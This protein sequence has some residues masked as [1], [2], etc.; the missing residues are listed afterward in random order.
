MTLKSEFDD[1]R[2]VNVGNVHDSNPI[3]VFGIDLKS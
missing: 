3:K 2:Y 1:D